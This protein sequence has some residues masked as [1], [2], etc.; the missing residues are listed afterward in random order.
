MRLIRKITP[1]QINR[2]RRDG[3]STSFQMWSTVSPL[4]V[5]PQNI[6]RKEIYM[7]LIKEGTSDQCW[8]VIILHLTNPYFWGTPG[9]PK[10]EAL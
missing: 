2:E 10:G 5:N 7:N 1:P 8:I 3:D 6:V 9:P 4:K